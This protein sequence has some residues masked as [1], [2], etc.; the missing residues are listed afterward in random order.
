MELGAER[1]GLEPSGPAS[2]RRNA[3]LRRKRAQARHVVA[4]T[5]E[6]EP[7]ATRPPD[8]DGGD[9]AQEHVDAVLHVHHPREDHVE[10][11]RAPSVHGWPRVEA[12]GPGPDD[13]RALGWHVAVGHGDVAVR[14]V[15][16]HHEVRVPIAPAFDDPQRGSEDP[17]GQALGAPLRV[18]ELGTEVVLVVHDA[19]VTAQHARQER[20]AIGRVG[21]MEHVDAALA[22]DGEQRARRTRKSRERFAHLPDDPRSVARRLPA[23]DRDAVEHR[24]RGL[25]GAAGC[26]DEHLIAGVAKRTR[27]APHPLVGGDRQILDAEHDARHRAPPAPGNGLAA[28][29][30]ASSH[31]YACG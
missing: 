17:S 30:A 19:P 9:G 22:L 16:Q 1:L 6:H 2:D 24:A 29:T 31:A 20:V 7:D 25:P 4:G 12:I 13:D 26:D 21:H 10:R 18:E 28:S 3:E 11:A 14:V 8:V 23:P 5:H 27:F 15:G